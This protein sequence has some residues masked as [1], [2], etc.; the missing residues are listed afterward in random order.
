[1]RFPPADSPDL[2]PI[3]LMRSKA[4]ALLRKAEVRTNEALLLALGDALSQETQKDAT[5]WFN[6]CGYSFIENALAA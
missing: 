4:K 2:N 1:M 6:H 5:H 3:E